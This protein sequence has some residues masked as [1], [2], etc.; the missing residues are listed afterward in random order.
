MHSRPAQ[1]LFMQ[2][3]NYLYFACLN[4]SSSLYLLYV[5]ALL[6]KFSC[7]LSL[8]FQ[9]TLNTFNLF[10]ICKISSFFFL[11][12]CR[13]L[14]ISWIVSE[15]R[16]PQV[17]FIEPLKKVFREIMKMPLFTLVKKKKHFIGTVAN[18]TINIPL[19]KWKFA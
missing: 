8:K 9:M 16:N 17:T 13:I 19:W 12:N 6:G 2:T 14:T 5:S 7:R 10:M 11:E 18:W 1:L 3:K 4:N 15:A